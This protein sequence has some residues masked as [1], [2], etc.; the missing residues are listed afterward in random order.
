MSLIHNSVHLTIL[1]VLKLVIQ[2]AETFFE[3]PKTFFLIFFIEI[4]VSRAIIHAT[5]PKLFI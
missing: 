5:S 2:I 4:H 1:P 3:Y